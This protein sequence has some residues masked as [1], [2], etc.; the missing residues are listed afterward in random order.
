MKEE[1]INLS[2]IINAMPGGRPTKRK[3]ELTTTRPR[4]LVE[5]P[6]TNTPTMK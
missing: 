3:N 5:E 4:E 1:K 6:H 2:D